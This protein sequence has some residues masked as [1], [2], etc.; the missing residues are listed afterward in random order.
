MSG[1]GKR[2]VGHR[3]QATAPVLDSTYTDVVDADSSRYFD[4]IPHSDLM[5]SV[6]RRIVDRHVLRLIKLWLKA[7]HPTG[8][9]GSN[10]A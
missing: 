4:T 2:S 9:L 5:K 8:S 6:A 3:P 7:P 10:P 1:D